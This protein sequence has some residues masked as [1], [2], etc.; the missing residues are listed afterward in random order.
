MK[1]LGFSYPLNGDWD[2]APLAL[3]VIL[4]DFGSPF[5][6]VRCGF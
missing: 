3:V 5:V 4:D 1:E 2:Y 6:F